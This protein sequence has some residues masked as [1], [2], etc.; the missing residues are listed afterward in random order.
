MA[1]E[2]KLEVFTIYYHTTSDK[3]VNTFAN[4]LETQ[5]PSKNKSSKNAVDYDI[6]FKKFFE[7][8]LK[9]IDNTYHTDDKR[10]KAIGVKPKKRG[11]QN[12]NTISFATDKKIIEGTIK[13][14]RYGQKR[15]IGDMTKPEEDHTEIDYKKI[16]LDDFYFQLYCPLGSSKAILMLQ[17]YTDDTVRD[18][19]TSFLRDLFKTD[20]FY[21]PS[22]TL[23]CPNSIKEEFKKHSL[24][25]TVRFRDN[26]IVSDIE[27]N[28]T[29]DSKEVSIE[30]KITTHD[31]GINIK[32]F[33]KFRKALEKLGVKKPNVNKVMTFEDFADKVGTLANGSQ[34]S[35]FNLDSDFSITPTIYLRDKITLQ[36]DDTPDWDSLKDYCS[37]LLLEVI[38]EVYPENE[39]S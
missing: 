33:N 9:K 17:S 22:I 18:I 25:K 24:I 20:G 10:K 34:I 4:Y 21:K 29:I 8:F 39:A 5:F 11:S 1:H 19:F 31:E 7:F 30:I 38:E 13:G 27:N 2:P 16:V 12:Q 26:I 36:L 32:T 14:G 28:N 3:T 23:F 6:L 37:E 35:S 15:Y